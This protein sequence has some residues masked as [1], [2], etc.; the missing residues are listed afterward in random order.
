ME[1]LPLRDAGGRPGGHRDKRSL[2]DA[3]ISLEYLREIKFRIIPLDV[4]GVMEH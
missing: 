2:D 4:R 1:V 3:V